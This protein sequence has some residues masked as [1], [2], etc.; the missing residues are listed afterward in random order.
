MQKLI[1]CLVGKSGAGKDTMAQQLS[2]NR[3][4]HNVISCT[5]RP[6][7]EYEENGVDYYFYDEGE[8]TRK[9]LNGEFLEVTRFNDWF[10]GTLESSL[11]DGINIGVWNPEGYDCLRESL[12]DEKEIKLL[13]YYLICD[14]KTR[15]L[16]QLDREE[17]PDVHEIVRRFTADE[18]D[19]AWLEDVS[20]EE[21]PRLTNVTWDDAQKNIDQILRQAENYYYWDKHD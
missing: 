2:Q 21:L 16:R 7:R 11:E 12:Q 13:A 19:F 18:E 8:F 14:D 1:V 6:P 20:E 5:T 3:N 9:L 17:Q 10:Y 15:L 4:W